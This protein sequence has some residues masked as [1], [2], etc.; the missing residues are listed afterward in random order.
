VNKWVIGGI[1]AAVV[2]AIAI[3]AATLWAGRRRTGTATGAT[4]EPPTTPQ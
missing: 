2:V 1:G 3:V 4:D